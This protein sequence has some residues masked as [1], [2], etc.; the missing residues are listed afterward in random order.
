MPVMVTFFLF[1]ADWLVPSLHVVCIVNHKAPK[2][3]PGILPSAKSLNWYFWSISRETSYINYIAWFIIFT[4]ENTLTSQQ[5]NAYTANSSVI[6]FMNTH[7]LSDFPK[8]KRV[9]C[10]KP[11]SFFSTMEIYVSI[12]DICHNAL[13]SHWFSCAN[14]LHVIV[15]YWF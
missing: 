12:P 7:L 9:L 6:N 1:L 15:Y 13:H 5:G 8:L 14:I 10:N 4:S 11:Q 2:F 3:H